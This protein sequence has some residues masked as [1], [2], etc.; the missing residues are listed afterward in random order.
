PTL[1][2]WI[3]LQRLREEVAA[4]VGSFAILAGRSG[5]FASERLIETLTELETAPGARHILGRCGRN[6]L[7][8][9]AL[10]EPSSVD[11]LRQFISERAGLEEETVRWGAASFPSNGATAEELWS[12]AMDRLL[13]LEAQERVWTDPCMTRLRAL[14]D[15]WSQRSGIVL[16]GAEGV[17]RESLAR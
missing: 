12:L 6:T 15:R 8:V 17:G 7:E 10:G 14:A 16:I 1:D 11:A 13:G 9:L 4:A 2:H 3:W 5:A